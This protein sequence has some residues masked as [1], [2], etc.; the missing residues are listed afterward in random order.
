MISHG[1]CRAMYYDISNEVVHY[2]YNIY[3]HIYIY[4]SKTKNSSPLMVCKQYNTPPKKAGKRVMVFL[5]AGGL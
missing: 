2:I 1:T 5:V 4:E 3:I